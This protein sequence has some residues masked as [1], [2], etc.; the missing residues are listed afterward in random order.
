[1]G[2]KR[3]KSSVPSKFHSILKELYLS[4]VYIP[5]GDI[6][7]RNPV[8]IIIN[9]QLMIRYWI[10]RKSNPITIVIIEAR[11]LTVQDLSKT[12]DAFVSILVEQESFGILVDRCGNT[13]SLE[14][15]CIKEVCPIIGDTDL[16][17]ID[18]PLFDRLL[19]Y[20]DGDESRLGLYVLAVPDKNSV[21]DKNFELN[22]DADDVYEKEGVGPSAELP[23]EE[24]A[25]EE[26]IGPHLENSQVPPFANN[27]KAFFES[28]FL[29]EVDFKYKDR[30]TNIADRKTG[31]AFSISC[32]AYH[33]QLHTLE[34][35]APSLHCIYFCIDKIGNNTITF[36]DILEKWHSYLGSYF[37][38]TC[39]YLVSEDL[40]YRE[41]Y[42]GKM[43]ADYILK[44]IGA[45]F[46]P[47]M[48]QN[49]YRYYK[50]EYCISQADR[51]CTEVIEGGGLS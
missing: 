39:Y 9:K 24:I 36:T 25:E 14:A 29:E 13:S 18:K 46:L 40:I 1:M 19:V 16:V 35:Q 12:Y 48:H 45:S 15:S 43:V 7:S 8:V 26:D 4:F 42:R 32:N 6:N 22:E 34:I 20:Y 41:N 33:P 49:R 10:Y 27:V 3:K 2:R 50:Y 37:A 44:Y 11:P 47:L 17:S 28:I 23:I 30:I 51:I 31:V 21:P 38:G 5:E